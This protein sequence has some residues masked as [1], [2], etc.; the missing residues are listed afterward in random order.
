MMEGRGSI[1]QTEIGTKFDNNQKFP[2]SPLD[3]T[4]QVQS[5]AVPERV[6]P[7]F[8]LSRIKWTTP[9][10]SHTYVR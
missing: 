6:D 1:L 5:D 2:S 7:E 10:N 3:R 8:R 4:V 9:W